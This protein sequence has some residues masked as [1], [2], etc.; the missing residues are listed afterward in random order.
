[1]STSTAVN[2]RALAQ[3]A[4]VPVGV[5]VVAAW[6]LVALTPMDRF[7]TMWLAMAVA[8]MVPSVSRPLA[9]A[10]DGSP[11][12]A[13]AFT[14]GFVAVWA[15]A[16]VPALLL[17]RAITWTPGALALAWAVA[18]AWQLLPWVRRQLV[19]CRSVGY[20][21]NPSA[22]G[23]RQGLRCVTSC[24][25][26]MIAA[27]ATMMLLPQL[28][29]SMLLLVAVTALVCWQKSPLRSSRTLVVVGMA[30]LLLGAVS[31][32][33]VGNGASAGHPGHAMS[34]GSTSAQR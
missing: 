8:M 23:L 9:R 14:A 24:G 17:G 5:V 29:L 26:L 32:T 3:P 16:G 1:M 15:A 33:L 2:R 34:M 10:A 21:G 6:V 13:L 27:G 31:W 22:Y 20:H 7:W 4:L 12:R 11:L 19:T 28:W 25:P 18:G 30:M